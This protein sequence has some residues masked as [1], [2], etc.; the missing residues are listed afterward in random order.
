M[1]T[2]KT[3]QL[4][5]L[6]MVVVLALAFVW[7]SVSL[8]G[9]DQMR[10]E[11]KVISK[12]NIS[13]QGMVSKPQ[14][15]R[16]ISSEFV[17]HYV[18]VD[19]LEKSTYEIYLDKFIVWTKDTAAILKLVDNP[20]YIKN[21]GSDEDMWAITVNTGDIQKGVTL[22]N[23]LRNTPEVLYLEN[24]VYSKDDFELI[25]TRCIHV[26]LSTASDSSQ[27]KQIV[28]SLHLI[29]KPY[30]PKID[31]G[32]R[33]NLELTEKTELTRSEI[34]EFLVNRINLKSCEY[35]WG[36]NQAH[37]YFTYD[38]YIDL[39]CIVSS[40]TSYACPAVAGV[41]ALV[42]EANAN[43]TAEQVRSIIAQSASLPASVTDTVT[44]EYGT[45]N[46]KYGYGIVNAYEAVK[47]AANTGNDK[48]ILVQLPYPDISTVK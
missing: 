18:S 6:P 38:T 46:Q 16:G 41:A 15:V 1:K 5:S 10:T 8:R 48:G 2:S 23:L 47:L 21:I 27:F 32:R 39:Q 40:G 25:P 44:K 28:D 37:V 12:N 19:P 31:L 22:R 36:G 30:K 3:R 33:F 9:Q 7:A 35:R 24:Y 11:P 17:D 43:A 29:I 13:Q 14:K 26:C 20:N 45:W 42:L 34:V 4:R